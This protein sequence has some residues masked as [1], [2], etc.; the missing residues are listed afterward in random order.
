MSPP[1]PGYWRLRLGGPFGGKRPGRRLQTGV[2][3]SEARVRLPSRGRWTNYFEVASDAIA[4]TRLARSS[5]PQ[6]RAAQEVPTSLRH[7]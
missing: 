4:N 6:A 7:R 5:A 2:M 1:A 3:R